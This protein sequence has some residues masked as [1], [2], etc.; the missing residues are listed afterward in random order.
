V[1]RRESSSQKGTIGRV[2]HEYKH[3][4][5]ESGRPGKAGKVKSRKQAVAIALREA[6]ASNRQSAADNKKSLRKTKAKER[7]G[8]TAQAEKEGK[9]AQ[10]RTE[11]KY[12]A[13]GKSRRRSMH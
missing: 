7:Q 4:E 10:K 13:R 11:R 1:P 6:G 9:A 3:G 2:M 8:R 5:L 12:A